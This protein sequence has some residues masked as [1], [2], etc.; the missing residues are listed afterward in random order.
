ME[1]NEYK[2]QAKIGLSKKDKEIMAND[3]YNRADAKITPQLNAMHET[4]QS[5]G[6]LKPSGVD[7]S[8]NI[9]SYTENKGVYVA[10]DTGGWYYWNGSS[11]V[12]GGSFQSDINAV[13]LGEIIPESTIEET[14]KKIHVKIEEYTEIQNSYN[15]QKVYMI[16]LAD[17]DGSYGTC[18]IIRDIWTGDCYI[19]YFQQENIKKYRTGYTGDDDILTC[20][21]IF[22]S[23]ISIANG[24]I[25]PKKTNF[26]NL[27]PTQNLLDIKVVRG[28]I[29]GV[30]YSVT[31]GKITFN[32]TLTNGGTIYLDIEP[33]IL[34]GTYTFTI[35]SQVDI[36]WYMEL[37]DDTGTKI[38]SLPSNQPITF[39][40][41]N[42]TATRIMFNSGGGTFNNL[43]ITPTMVKGEY[44]PSEY[45]EPYTYELNENIKLKNN[46][47]TPDNVNFI[48]SVATEN[49]LK[50][51]NTKVVI[52]GV[53]FSVTN[54][55]ITFNGTLTNPGT[56]YLYIEPVKLNG[57]YTF[58][59][60]SQVDIGWYMEL[61]DDTGEKISSLPSNQP[62]TFNVENKTATRIMFNSGGGTFDNLK[63]TP[64]LVK[65]NEEPEQYILPY[66]YELDSSIK[67]KEKEFTPDLPIL[68]L[69][70]DISSMT[71]EVEAQLNYVYGERT[72]TCS[73]KWQGSGSLQYPKKNYTIK[74]DNEF[75][76]KE[77]WGSHKKYCLKA[78]WI[79]TTHSRNVFGAKLWGEFVKS[80]SIVPNE[81]QN[82]PNYGAIDGFPIW[83]KINGEDIGL[84]TFNIPKDK[85]MFGMGNVSTEAFINADKWHDMTAWKEPPI[86]DNENFELEYAGDDNI[87]R[88]QTSLTNCYNALQIATSEN[89]EE[90]LAPYLDIDSVIDSF[91]FSTITYNHDRGK[92]YLMTT[93]NG[94]KWFVTEY[95]LDCILG[96]WWDGK[97]FM[98]SD[99]HTFGGT[100]TTHK[101]YSWVYDNLRNKVKTRYLEI[102]DKLNED[103][104]LK[105]YSDYLSQFP[106][107]CFEK[108][109]QI[110]TT[111]PGTS[112]NTPSQII[113]WYNRRLSILDKEVE[114]W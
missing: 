14:M 112:S 91:I 34:N 88:V 57:T 60:F 79:D 17:T 5:L 98:R 87:E 39:N 108:D 113:L 102:R 85:Y 65:G 44:P 92:N 27:K 53:N 2:V 6:G 4:I 32:G 63:I 15:S 106:K 68:Y 54:G 9:L 101:M 70:G 11:Y 100:A 97:T 40:V 28:N 47:V 77:G 37:Q 107:L 76:A 41:E 80:R 51:T 21:E 111:I 73:L 78:N 90:V 75:E 13:D 86:I 30:A 8:S 56:I 20:E 55:E 74:F 69:K 110:W 1:N 81:L 93:F 103:I 71:K 25:T 22:L 31:D 89:Y 66:Q 42:K 43:K 96:V 94:V 99:Y 58:T 45:I 61:Q 50:L 29:N 105:M 38:S 72:G 84:F 62:I 67:V 24:S 95:D 49:L 7:S 48:K 33:I 35:F 83:I 46:S 12:Y 18:F 26:I 59:I 3:V 64:M 19:T 16:L 10:N 114:K 109:N 23:N 36:G 82:L 52:N 104:F